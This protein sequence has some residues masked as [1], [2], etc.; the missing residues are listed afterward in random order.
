MRR[1]SQE[2]LGARAGMDQTAISKLE[3][4]KVSEPLFSK[5]IALADALELDPHRLKFGVEASAL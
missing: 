5:G 2:A 3:L 4:G 1:L